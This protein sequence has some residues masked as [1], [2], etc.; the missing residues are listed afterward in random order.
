MY[1]FDKRPDRLGSDAYKW[2]G[3]AEDVIPMWVA[4]MDIMSPPAI[5]EAITKRVQ[6]PY[7]GYPY[8]QEGLTPLVV[9]HYKKLYGVRVEKEWILWLPAVIPGVAAALQ[10]IGGIFA[11]SVPMYDHIRS[12][13]KETG[14]DCIEVPLGLDGA[15]RY[16]MDLAVLDTALGAEVKSYVLCS[17]HNPVGRVFDKA[18]LEGLWSFC[19]K[20]GITVI[21]DEIHCE[22]DFENRH[23]PFF[24]LGGEAAENSVTVSSA[25]KIC[26]IPGLPLG[27]AIVPNPKLRAA[28]ARRLE[29]LQA[30]GNV[31]TLAAYEKAYDGSCDEWK[32][33]LRA[34]LKDNRDMAEARLNAIPELKTTHNEGTYLLWV[35]CSALGLDD[36]SDFFLQKARVRLSAGAN[37]G[38]KDFVRL[39][40]GCPRA[41]LEE[42]LDRMEAAVASLR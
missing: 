32:A 3:A 2:N 4:D 39:N 5:I 7:Y 42:A 29:G 23:I 13:G 24:A 11:Y 15:N 8:T 27:F 19:A 38:N 26:N 37:Y 17:P 40:F 25:G 34:Y 36:P 31:I 6:H 22:L 35:D 21:S 41:Q 9:D 16:Y 20:H 18:E 28:V 1:G 12:L 14:L 33:A 10:A 30:S